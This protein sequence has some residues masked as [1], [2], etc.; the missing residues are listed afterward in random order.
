MI[1]FYVQW[2]QF[3]HEDTRAKFL[4]KKVKQRTISSC[5]ICYTPHH[6]IEK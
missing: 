5:E 4:I 2:P 1:S 6:I 3:E